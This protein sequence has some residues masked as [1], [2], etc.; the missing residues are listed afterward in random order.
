MVNLALELKID[1]VKAIEPDVT[2]DFVSALSPDAL[3]FIE[4][5]LVR[6]KVLKMDSGVVLDKEAD[7]FAFVPLGAVHIE[8]DSVASESSEHVIKDLQESLSVALGG[9]Y[10][11][12]R[13]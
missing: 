9:A 3:L 6:G 2:G 13:S 10:E 5:W 7:C 8:M 4:G 11:F 1:A 12:T